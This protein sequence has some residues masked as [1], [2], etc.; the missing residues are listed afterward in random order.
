MASGTVSISVL[1]IDPLNRSFAILPK[2]RGTTIRKE[3]RAASDL[4]S[5]KMTEVEMVAPLLDIP[6]RIAIAWA[7]PIRKASL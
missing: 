4:S 1:K 3:K 5:P 2:I 7:I 6:G